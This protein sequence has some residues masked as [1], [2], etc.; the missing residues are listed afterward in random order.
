MAMFEQKGMDEWMEEVLRVVYERGF[1]NIIFYASNATDGKD[2]ECTEVLRY[3]HCSEADLTNCIS[4]LEKAR[5][6]QW[7][8]DM[9]DDDDD[10]GETVD[11]TDEDEAEEG[12]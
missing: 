9:L 1:Q 6:R 2:D 3:K 11:V 8:E 5:I 4:L 12:D 10:S 7:L